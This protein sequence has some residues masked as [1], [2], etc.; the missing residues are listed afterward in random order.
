MQ[1]L[2][3]IFQKLNAEQTKLFVAQ[4]DYENGIKFTLCSKVSQQIFTGCST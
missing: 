1:K 4:I 3:V 2:V